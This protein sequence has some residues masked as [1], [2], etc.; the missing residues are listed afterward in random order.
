MEFVKMH[1]AGN[2][3][4][5]VEDLEGKLIND[6]IEIAKKVCHRHFGIGA[7]GLILIRKSEVADVKMV[8]IN[9]DGSRAN[10]CGNATRCFGRY[11]YDKKLVMKNIINVETGDGI[12]VVNLLFGLDE[13][14]KGARVYMGE[15]SYKGE[16]YGLNNRAELINEDVSI[17]D[18][19]YNLT[20]M[21]MGVPHTIVNNSKEEYDV[22]EGKNIEKYSL[23]NEGTNV[24][25]VNVLNKNEIKVETWERGAGAT[26]A[27]G[28]GCCASAVYT[29]NMNLTDEKVKVYT[30][31]GE[32]L[33]EVLEDGVYMT[34]GAEYICKGEVF[35]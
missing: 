14:F 19:S 28:T 13:S 31:G 27:C 25:F 32:L 34:G 3:F 23:F 17:G 5:F 6:E 26:L 30:K 33:I 12:K 4:I 16:D 18:K 11:V 1:G 2:D 22:I 35:I 10:M 24:N 8:I 15:A 21:L 9:S 20:T 7:D 29:K